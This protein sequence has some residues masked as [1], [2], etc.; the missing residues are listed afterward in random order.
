MFSLRVR[1]FL[2]DRFSFPV[3]DSKSMYVYRKE[4]YNRYS[5][6]IGHRL[7][8]LAPLAARPKSAYLTRCQNY[9]ELA[10]E[11]NS[12]ADTLEKQLDSKITDYLYLSKQ[13]ASAFLEW[14]TR[15]RLFLPGAAWDIINMS[16]SDI[17]KIETE[18]DVTLPYKKTISSK[19][20][21]PI[22]LKNK[23]LQESSKRVINDYALHMTYIKS[24]QRLSNLIRKV[25]STSMRKT[26]VFT[27]SNISME[28]SEVFRDVKK[29][30]LA[31]ASRE[32]VRSFAW[33]RI[34]GV[35]AG[36]IYRPDL[37]SE[38]GMRTDFHYSFISLYEL[39]NYL[40]ILY[41]GDGVG[42]DNETLHVVTAVILNFV[43]CFG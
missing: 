2:K 24:F 40:C 1:F 19:V 22:F 25:M 31:Q 15:F 18:V 6:G 21:S 30:C 32:D 41:E 27:Q 8:S 9:A 28:P 33:A 10:E 39:I 36:E 7:P 17:K 11:F 43:L 5:D 29:R 12:A 23:D 35:F 13:S 3:S 34:K 16:P 14:S 26:A 20:N 4:G 38:V 42:S 37:S